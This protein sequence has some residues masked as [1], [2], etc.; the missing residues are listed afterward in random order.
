MR[1]STALLAEMRRREFFF[2]G[3]G[4]FFL[5]GVVCLGWVVGWDLPRRDAPSQLATPRPSSVF[6]MFA[7]DFDA[8][9]C[10]ALSDGS[11]ALVKNNYCSVPG[12]PFQEEDLKG[13]CC[14]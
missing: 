9:V 1:W 14:S 5:M 2:P 4:F 10:A 13:Q 8:E 3:P 7:E 6:R 11:N 12:R